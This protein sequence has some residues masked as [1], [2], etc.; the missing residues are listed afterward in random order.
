[1]DIKLTKEERKK[2]RENLNTRYS[3]MLPMYTSLIERAD[4]VETCAFVARNIQEMMKQ[5]AE[6]K[7]SAAAARGRKKR[8]TGPN[9]MVSLLETDKSKTYKHLK[10]A[11]ERRDYAKLKK[12]GNQLVSPL[13]VQEKKRKRKKKKSAPKKNLY[14]ELSS[15]SPSDPNCR[16]Q[17]PAPRDNRS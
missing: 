13:E 14:P 12:A 2:W 11:S 7:A 6:M 9:E 1:M 8:D 5:V 17:P 10:K 4:T 3:A 16:K 15:M